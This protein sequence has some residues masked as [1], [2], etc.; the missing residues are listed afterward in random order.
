M[1]KS[2]SPSVSKSNKKVTFKSLKMTDKVAKSSPSSLVKAKGKTPSSDPKV[3][4]TDNE[5]TKASSP[6]LGK[7]RSK[8]ASNTLEQLKDEM[9]SFLGNNNGPLMNLSEATTS[10]LLFYYNIDEQDIINTTMMSM[11]DNSTYNRKTSFNAKFGGIKMS[12][13]ELNSYQMMFTEK[14]LNKLYTVDNIMALFSNL[15]KLDMVANAVLQALILMSAIS[16]T[17][18]KPDGLK[19]KIPPASVQN[20]TKT[21]TRRR[22][23]FLLTI[24]QVLFYKS[25]S[26]A[27]L[28]EKKMSK[29]Q[30]DLLKI[31]GDY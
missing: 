18:K 3:K 16:L 19:I 20:L 4:K 14:N 10:M 25:K 17:K 26:F 22:L 12:L 2:S 9:S 7:T 13:K 6:S 31:V 15:E 11:V 23:S 24:S 5:T 27:K 29:M 30:R 21:E 28:D 1:T 8:T